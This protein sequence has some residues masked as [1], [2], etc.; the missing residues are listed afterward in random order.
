MGELQ[1]RVYLN[2]ERLP[3]RAVAVGA[4]H[5]SFSA[6]TTLTHA[7]AKVVA[8]VTE[9]ER[10]QSC[11]AFRLATAARWRVP[12][13]TSTAVRRIHA[14]ADGPPATGSTA[15]RGWPACRSP[16]A[17]PAQPVSFSVNGLSLPVTGFP[18]MSRHEP[19]AS[20]STPVPEGRPSTRCWRP[21]QSA[22]SPRGTWCT[23]RKPRTSPRCPAGTPP[24]SI[25]AALRATGR[26]ADADLTGAVLH[27][28]AG[29]DPGVQI[30]V[31]AE[32]PLLWI[33]PNVIAAAAPETV[34]PLGRFVLRSGEFRRIT[35]LEARQ[36]GRLLARS[37]PVW[38]IPGRPVHLGAGWLPRVDPAGGPVRVLT[39]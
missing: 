20:I 6:M 32:P 3:G 25:A 30:P 16:T 8:L 39:V 9:H 1:Q 10:Q 24:R 26:G 38:L 13:W 21:R 5:V 12:V 7:G 33:S 35:R 14:W 36:D 34:P 19:V 22:C 17:A 4:E 15:G 2:G 27:V 11:A 28:G 29:L 37:R 31:R 23:R 18:T